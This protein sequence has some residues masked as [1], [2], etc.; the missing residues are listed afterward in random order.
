M[1]GG[2]GLEIRIKADGQRDR[3]HTMEIHLLAKRPQ[4]ATVAGRRVKVQEA[5]RAR[6]PLGATA[7]TWDEARKTLTVLLPRLPEE[8]IIVRAE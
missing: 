8:G 3:K 5:R 6:L 7:A 4:T 1:T 2:E